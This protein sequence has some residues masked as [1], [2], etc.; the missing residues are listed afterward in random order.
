MFTLSEVVKISNGR[1]IGN[2]EELQISGISTDS[3]TLVPGD[4]FVALKGP[5]FDGHRFFNQ[6]RERGAV[7][8]LVSEPIEN[9]T[10]PTIVVSDTL[11]AFQA[12]A[13]SY[14]SRFSIP[15]VG[16]TGSV[17]KTTTKECIAVALSEVFRVR[18]GFGN[19]NNHIG[20]PVNLL[21]LSRED[22]CL[23]LELGANHPGEIKQLSE[24]ARPTVGVITAVHPVHL[25]G[26]GSLQGVYQAKLELADFV[27]QNYGTIIANG[28]D[29][30]LMRRLK[31]RKCSVITFGSSK[32]CDY[33]LTDLF[34]NDGIIYFKVNDQFEFRLNGYGAFNAS[35]ALAAIAV[36]GYFKLNLSGLAE[37]WQALPVIQGRFRIER[38]EAQNIVIVDDSYNANPISVK[39]A[40]QSFV[41][42]VP[43]KRKLMIMG[44]ML[45]LGEHSGI[46]H[47]DLGRYLA[48]FDFDY[49][50]G[51]G[52]M[53]QI[54]LRTFDKA[55]RGGKTVHFQNALE[56]GQ[57]LAAHIQEND[58]I[59]IKGSHGV[60]LDQIRPLL[61]QAIEPAIS[62]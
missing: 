13:Q 9:P 55:E 10:L 60:R 53:S 59:F 37:S 17:G 12:L 5:N 31:N 34:A 61:I 38:L 48:E 62:V 39:Q 51:V 1:L 40:V 8:A 29:S 49:L 28:D 27:E 24:I 16:V 32:H 26:F 15:V 42:L 25:E 41:R 11:T 50:L 3:R 7:C 36:A 22:Q 54:V 30:E 14:R 44:D 18:V 20:V 23:V 19:W 46:Y 52:P 2:A 57:F 45:E 6:A 35:N 58:A 21:R 4:L 43:G 47:E 33:R 56:A